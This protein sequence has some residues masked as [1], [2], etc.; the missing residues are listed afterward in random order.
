MKRSAITTLTAT[1][2]L[3]ALTSLAS[4][5]AGISV[6]PSGEFLAIADDL[7]WSNGAAQVTCSVTLHGELHELIGKRGDML[8]GLVTGGAFGG[9]SSN[10]GSE[11]DVDL[12]FPAPWHISYRGFTGELPNIDTLLLLVEDAAFLLEIPFAP[13]GEV[14]IQC[15][16]RGNVDAT[17]N[18]AVA[19]NGLLSMSA[20]ETGSIPVAG[21]LGALGGLCPT[22][23]NFDEDPFV[24]HDPVEVILASE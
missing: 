12:L 20:D 24:L 15:L 8:A 18:G 17:T 11:P 23:L 5:E 9:C 13:L 2:V 21:R 22:E 3:A 1:L 19:E 6:E 4:A 14:P 7:I 16:F 10:V